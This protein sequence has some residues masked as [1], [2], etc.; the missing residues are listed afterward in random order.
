MAAELSHSQFE[1]LVVQ[2][3]KPVVIDVYATW[4]PPC[5]QLAPHF[6]AVAHELGNQYN[7]YKINIDEE[8]ELAAQFGVTSI[9]TLLFLQKGE[10]VGRAMG[11]M[12]AD[13]LKDKIKESFD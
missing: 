6:E 12:S 2:S 7:F 5:K 13:Y 1:E 9:P 3:S 11:Y 10:E 8:S 4:C